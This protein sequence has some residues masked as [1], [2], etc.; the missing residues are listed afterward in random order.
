MRLLVL[1]LVALA[2][3]LVMLALVVVSYHGAA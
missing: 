3:G 2:L 1:N